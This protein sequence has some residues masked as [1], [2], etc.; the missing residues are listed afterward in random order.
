MAKKSPRVRKAPTERTNYHQQT[1]DD[2]Q[3][4]GEPNS[5]EISLEELEEQ[6]NDRQRERELAVEG[7]VDTQHSDGSAYYPLEADQ[8]G[9]VYIPPDDPPVLPSD[10]PQ[11]IEMGS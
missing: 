3:V 9:L 8:Q 10:D 7:P 1:V 4:D 2:L 5:V 11:G 6:A